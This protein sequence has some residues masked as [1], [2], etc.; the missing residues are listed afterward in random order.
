M[1][2]RP[3]TLLAA[4]LAVVWLSLA[5]PAP[6]QP[7]SSPRYDPDIQMRQMAHGAEQRRYGLYVPSTYR[8]DQPAPAI[9]ALHGRFSSAKAFH[10]L[11]G[12]AAIAEQRGAILIYP[13]PLS[14]GWGSGAPALPG[15]DPVGDDLGYLAALQA[16]VGRTHP[17]DPA[18]TFLV[19]YDTGGVMAYRAVCRGPA[20][21]AGVMI[22]S[23]L[24]WDH[25]RAECAAGAN[26]TPTLVVHG[27]RDESFP[28]SGADPRPGQTARRLSAA[29]TL[30]VLRGV[31]G[32]AGQGQTGRDGSV[33]YASCTG[34]PLAFVGL[35]RGTNDWFR[36][37]A[38]YRL[39][40]LGVDAT[41]L[42]DGFLFDRASFQLPASTGS[43]TARAWFVYAPPSYDPSK[44]TPVVVLLH[45]RPSN[46]T[47]MA[48]MTRMN[49][50]A[51]KKGFLVV[52][53]EGINNEWNAFYDL[54]RQRSL[55][56]QD[57]IRFLREL[58]AD[59]GQDFNI[60]RR[61]AYVGGY[62]NG[63][64]MTFRLACSM[65]DTFAGFAAVDATLYTVL[66]DKC[67]GGTATPILIMNGT[68]DPSVSYTGVSVEDPEGRETRV[69]LSVPETVAWFINR[70]DCSMVGATTNLPPRG[71]SPGTSVI[72]FAPKDCKKAPVMFWRIDGGG[73]TW[74]GV[75]GPTGDDTFGPTNMDINAG[76][77]IWEF[78]EPLSLREAPAD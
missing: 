37:G 20:R 8:A 68:A 6:A 28:A 51:D 30:A 62:S 9:V 18:R 13:E 75:G 23:A 5:G 42:A 49:D 78:F 67:R 56:P 16:E 19:G 57:D 76:E 3:S 35:G 26:P 4:A 73:H 66:K 29:D 53:P 32:C 33:W 43:G 45:G 24:M 61:R 70:N 77:V 58:L 55:A 60:D 31:N 11:T 52:Y 2:V 69:T 22:V 72:R 64:F 27:R 12:L 7:R 14:L 1:G 39:N 17:L 74:P 50:V 63:G 38:N 46:A 15:A 65:A 47:S 41:R 21:W 71:R 48:F 34:A 59:L 36:D 44:P 54:T 40:R 25:T 10:A